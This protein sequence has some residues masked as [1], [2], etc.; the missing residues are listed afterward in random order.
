MHDSC[1]TKQANDLYSKV[2]L[3]CEHFKLKSCERLANFNKLVGNN[4]YY[5]QKRIANCSQPVKVD[6][7]PGDLSSATM[8][9]VNSHLPFTEIIRKFRSFLAR[10]TDRLHK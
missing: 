10:S 2:Q 9:H 5:M 7:F 8:C 3:T 6:G 1:K 4:E